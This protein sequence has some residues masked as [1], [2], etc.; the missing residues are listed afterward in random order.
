MDSS[1]EDVMVL[2]VAIVNKCGA[3]RRSKRDHWV[4]PYIAEKVSTYDTFAAL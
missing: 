1:D 4:H 3:W 2:T